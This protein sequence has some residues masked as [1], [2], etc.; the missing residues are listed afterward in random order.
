MHDMNAWWAL[1]GIAMMAIFWGGL[2]FFAVWLA[3]SFL[4]HASDDA[5]TIAR[6]RYARGEISKDDFERLNHD[7]GA[8]A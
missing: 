3:R 4:D 7:L 6:Q 2:I 8:K 5:L 1:W